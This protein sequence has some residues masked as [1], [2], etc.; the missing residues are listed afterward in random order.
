M[1]LYNLLA[2]AEAQQKAVALCTVVDSRGSTPRH[3]GSKMLVYPD[4]RIV[5]SVG[6]G[7]IETRTITEALLALGDGKSRL[8]EMDLT[9]PA[10]GDAGVCGGQVTVFIEPILANPLLVVVGGGHVGKAVC[11]LAHWLGF[12]VAVSDDRPEFCTPEAN[13]DAQYF[14]PLALADLPKH[15]SI[16]SQTYI[17]LTTRGAEVDITGLPALLDTPAAYLGVIGSKRRWTITC[18]GLRKAGVVEEKISRVHSPVG[19]ELN[20]ETPEE[21]AVSIMAEII[22]LR[23]GGTGKSMKMTE[24]ACGVN[25]S[26]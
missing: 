20:A 14:Y 13:P 15:L 9:D 25:T 6:G 3:A 7:E 16:S 19:L 23:N 17:V 24:G 10:R 5:G 12:R 26:V 22:Q 11:H 2:E 4:R 18:E 21:I 1:A 8:L